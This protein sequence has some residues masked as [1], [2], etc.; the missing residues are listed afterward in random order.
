[1]IGDVFIFGVIAFFQGYFMRLFGWRRIMQLFFWMS[2]ASL[3]ASAAMA[4][5]PRFTP[6]ILVPFTMLAGWH[7]S[8]RFWKLP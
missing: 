6:I 7:Q 4:A 1:M 8:W 3:V 2:C 5:S